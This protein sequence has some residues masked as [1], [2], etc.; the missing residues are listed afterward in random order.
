MAGWESSSNLSMK[1]VRSAKNSE[2][3][4]WYKLSNEPAAWGNLNGAPTANV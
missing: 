1:E 3:L 4:N 2:P